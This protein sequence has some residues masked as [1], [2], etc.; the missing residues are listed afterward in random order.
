M[1]DNGFGLDPVTVDRVSQE[2]AD[3]HNT[4]TEIALV[5]GGGNIFRGISGAL[6]GMDRVGSDHMGMLATVINGLALKNALKRHNID[7]RVMSAVPI[8]AICESFIHDRAI[9]HLT[10]KRVVI[11]VA[12]LGSPFFTTD[13]AATLRASEMNCNALF[14][15]TK[16]PGVYDQDP[17]HNPEANRYSKLSYTQVLTDNLKI[18]DAPAIALASEI[19]LPII[20]FSIREP[21]GL[22]SALA[23]QGNYTII[24]K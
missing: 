22:N 3:V 7:T 21:G 9:S 17:E 11:F 10:K 14:K 19:N 20:I 12:G 24:S 15:G 4:G 13:T 5:I 8:P 23:Q 2:I 6:Y 1:G 16:V 18:M